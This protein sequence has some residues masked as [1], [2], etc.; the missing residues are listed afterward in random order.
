MSTT[1]SCDCFFDVAVYCEMVES[2]YRDFFNYCMNE[3]H[4]RKNSFVTM[5]KDTR[6]IACCKDFLKTL[7]KKKGLNK[8]KKTLASNCFY[9]SGIDSGSEDDVMS[10]INDEQNLDYYCFICQRNILDSF[11]DELHYIDSNIVNCF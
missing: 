3:K 11:S 9:S 1:K 10:C 2:P 7:I 6:F 4:G 5:R 8:I